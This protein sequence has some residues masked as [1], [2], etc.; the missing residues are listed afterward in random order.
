MENEQK[1]YNLGGNNKGILFGFLF[2]TAGI[3]FLGF[4]FG[5]FNPALREVIFSWPIILIIVS[6]F[7]F[8][9]RE[10]FNFMITLFLGLFFLLPRIANAFPGSLPGIDSNFSSNYWPVLLII[11]GICIIFKVSLW[12]KNEYKMCKTANN[13][14][15]GNSTIIEGMNGR[16]DK[17]VVFGGTEDIFL[18]PVFRGGNIEA[19]FGGV[20]IDLRK[21]HLPE[22]ET[23]LTI[24]AVFGGVTLYIPDEWLITTR[25]ETVMG[26]YTDKRLSPMVPIDATR[27]LVLQGDLVFGGCEIK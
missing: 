18:D 27:K 16:V 22:G 2:I 14:G 3:L 15:N 24:S 23:Y 8:V 11:V 25:F 6:L 17:S 13:A 19:V 10:Y 9:K 21:T 1:H 4:N 20:V 5:W 7:S 12:K 26:G